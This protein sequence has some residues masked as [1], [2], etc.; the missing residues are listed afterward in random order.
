MRITPTTS[1]SKGV[2]L[3]NA[4]GVDAGQAFEPTPVTQS[5]SGAP[6]STMRGI[7]RNAA[8]GATDAAA[9]IGNVATDPTGN[10]IGKPL[11]TL[12]VATHDWLAPMFG[13]K[14]FP[15]DVRNMLLDD[16]VPQPGNQVVNAVGAAMGAPS[17]DSIEA[18]GGA[19]RMARK[20]VGAA[21][22]AAAL[23]PAGAMLPAAVGAGGAMAGDLAA[24]VA[25]DWLK[26]AAEL[27]GNVA[28]GAGVAGSAVGLR[29]GGNLIARKAGEMGIGGKKDFGGVGATGAQAN[30]VG[31]KLAT[32]IG[33][34]GRQAIERA[35]DA[36]QQSRAL[37]KTL[38]DPA[39]A[40]ADR[41]VAQQQLQD[42]QGRRVSLVPDSNPTT[43]QV[44]QTA[45]AAALEKQSRLTHGP[46]FEEAQK[47]Q[48][49]A[50]V[51]AIQNLEPTGANPASVGGLFAQHLQQ[52][53][54]IGQHQIGQAVGGRDSAVYASGG[55]API[56]QYG[57]K[58]RETLQTAEDPVH[59]AAS[60]A[61]RAVDPNGSWTIQSAPLKD[62]ASK[63][64]I[65]VSPTAKTDAQTNA[66]LARGMSQP[67]VI[68]F[69][70]LSQMRA[71]ANDGLARLMRT[72]DAPS[73]VRRLTLFKQGIDQT[74]AKAVNDHAASDP[75]LVNR[76]QRQI[77]PPNPTVNLQLDQYDAEAAS[78]GFRR[79]GP[80]EPR[81]V[82]Q[83][84]ATDPRTGR[85][86]VRDDGQG[87]AP[88]VGGV[89]PGVSGG[90]GEPSGSGQPVGAT[91][92]SQRGP[93]G[94]TGADTL[95]AEAADWVKRGGGPAPASSPPAAPNF[96]AEE[97][98]KYQSAVAGWRDYMQRYHQGGVGDVLKKSDQGFKV[99]EG[100]VP[101]KIFTGGPTEPAQVAHFIEAIGGPDKAVEIGRNVLANDLRTKG[102]IKPDGTV[103]ANR[104]SL[105][106]R[107]RQATLQQF[108][109]LA[110]HF[111]SVETA[112]RTLNDV[113]AAH[114][115]A[116]D[117][118]NKS[119]A[120]SFIHDDPLRAVG[121]AFASSNPTET[122][123]QLAA[124]VRGTPS[125]EAGL[126]RAVVDYISQRFRS[127]TPSSD[128]IDFL[129]PGG[130][131]KWVDTNKGPLRILFGGQGM[132][133]LQMVAADMRRAAEGPK[134]IAGSQT[135]P[136]LANAKRLGAKIG[137]HG[138]QGTF[139]TLL[140]LFGERMGEHLGGHGIV[141][142]AASLGGGLVLNALRQS[143]IHTMEHLAAEAMLHPQLARTLM[144]R[145][146]ASK[147]L[148]T[149]AQRRIA[150][151]L[152]GALLADMA[153]TGEKRQ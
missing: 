55:T 59:Q 128:G 112:Q 2:D 116:V 145:A 120:A 3:F 94:A 10:M 74:I 67:A 47:A 80:N 68:P 93:A 140:T 118:F 92:A 125:A 54:Q 13:G 86:Y 51:G 18:H 21:G 31:N 123:R 78:A 113:T 139:L 7:A 71:D 38:A 141:A 115:A 15:D 100:N 28:G 127:A 96:G 20:V 77:Q 82:G 48:N 22:G 73:E 39:T 109:G 42:I 136:L 52:L 149:A 110:N 108:P 132:Q 81:S 57:A 32:N 134:A 35:T 9:T 24:Q 41:Q 11:A 119:A 58:M 44:A 79:I 76:L 114:K 150:V 64:A 65:E 8:A 37:E 27:A 23:S 43:A 46:E 83:E 69:S 30:A 144:E 49:N 85:E 99:Q 102:I 12:G 98:G 111:A 126:K 107:N 63:L 61:F 121:K 104:L 36:E 14:R 97:A 95:A 147:A 131:R 34:E 66:L 16:N 56:A 122:F 103:D 105:W 146:D 87:A 88:P 6:Q 17:P 117:A 45:G 129:Q 84:I 33:P 53:D 72:G 70:G 90:G 1:Q 26:P 5:K 148:S 133:D 91:G 152:Q 124:G 75:E 106:N 138:S 137:N 142:G 40:P 151:A 135:T 25:P 60:R 29:A 101:A 143:G 50:R 130:F 4:L 19:E 153:N 62:V 89:R